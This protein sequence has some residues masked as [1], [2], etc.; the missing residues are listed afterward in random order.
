MTAPTLPMNKFNSTSPRYLHWNYKSNKFEIHYEQDEITGHNKMTQHVRILCTRFCFFKTRMLIQRNF[1]LFILSI[2]A[3]IITFCLFKQ[4][5]L[6][7]IRSIFIKLLKY[8]FSSTFRQVS[9][10][11][12]NGIVNKFCFSII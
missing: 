11:I 8:T 9:F 6:H 2:Y 10:D 1:T 4:I 7:S 5:L 3:C 12:I